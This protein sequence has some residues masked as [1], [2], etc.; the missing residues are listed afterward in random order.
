MDAQKVL[1]AL[2]GDGSQ[3]AVIEKAI[4]MVKNNP[5]TTL[6]FL[7]VIETP[8]FDFLDFRN[9]VDPNVMKEKLEKEIK[10]FDPK[11]K[12]I[13]LVEFGKAGNIIVREAQKYGVDLIVMGAKTEESNT[14]AIGTATKSVLNAAISPVLIVKTPHMYDGKYLVLVDLTGVACAPKEMVRDKF[15]KEYDKGYLY[16]YTVPDELSLRYHDIATSEFEHWEDKTRKFVAKEKEKFESEHAG[17][18]L[19][20]LESKAGVA[21]GVASYMK[22]EGYHLVAIDSVYVQGNSSLLYDSVTFDVIKTVDADL[23][24]GF[25]ETD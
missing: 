3:G 25:C 11:P 8:L 2:S 20:T 12:F 14:I 4:Y 15:V 1:V 18:E 5:Q 21:A 24:I 17:I 19:V 13:V 6:V 7:H 10:A 16:V 23:L 9:S 22:K